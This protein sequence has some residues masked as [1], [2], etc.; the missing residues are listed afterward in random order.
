M[1]EE[2]LEAEKRGFDY[3]SR[4]VKSFRKDAHEVSEQIRA[5][6]EV[7]HPKKRLNHRNAAN[8]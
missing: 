3:L 8:Y 5:S 7:R 6:I 2:R 4:L 1:T